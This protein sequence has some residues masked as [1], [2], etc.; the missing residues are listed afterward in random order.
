[1]SP[2][3]ATFS[4][5]AVNIP[6]RPEPTKIS[7]ASSPSPGPTGLRHPTG[8][9]EAKVQP[10]LHSGHNRV[11][12]CVLQGPCGTIQISSRSDFTSVDMLGLP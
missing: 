2:S 1:M 4:H 6:P 3:C 8:R 7:E 11:C 12:F 5:D 9:K 10:C